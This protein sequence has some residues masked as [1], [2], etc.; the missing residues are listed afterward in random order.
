VSQPVHSIET[1]VTFYVLSNVSFQNVY[2]I[3]MIFENIHGCVTTFENIC[4]SVMIFQDRG[5]SLGTWT[6][7]VS[8]RFFQVGG[9]TCLTIREIVQANELPIFIIVRV[10]TDGLLAD[11][12]APSSRLF[13]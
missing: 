2:E 3:A 11:K 1:R 6:V 13:P 7:D 4:E 5:D 8:I 10:A 12:L 9:G